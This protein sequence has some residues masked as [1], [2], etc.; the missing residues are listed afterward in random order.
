[1]R[2]VKRN[3]EPED[4]IGAEELL[5]QP[6]MGQRGDVVRLE[7]AMKPMNPTRHQG[8]LQLQR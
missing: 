3:G 7:L 8:A 6:G 2:E 5:R 4:A 1:M